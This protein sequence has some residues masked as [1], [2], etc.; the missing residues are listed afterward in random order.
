[1]VC[2][3]EKTRCKRMQTYRGK[4]NLL[5]PRAEDVSIEDIAHALTNLCRYNG[6]CRPFYSVAEHC[7]HVADLCRPELHYAALLHDAAEARLL[8]RH[9]P[10]P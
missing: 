8:R 9:H 2:G 6:H 4:F 3:L 10:G 7:V 5:D 1:M